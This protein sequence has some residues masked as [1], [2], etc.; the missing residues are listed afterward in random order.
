[1]RFPKQMATISFFMSVRVSVVGGV[2][3]KSLDRPGRKQT[4]ATKLGIYLIYSPRY[5]IHFLARCSNI[6]KA[7]KKIQKFVRPTRSLRQRLPP[8]RTKNGEFSIVFQAKQQVVVRR[9]QIRITGLVIKKLE[10]QVGQFLLGCKCPVTLF[11]QEQDPLGE[12]PAKFFIQNA[13]QL[14]QQR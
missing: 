2:A 3:D 10:A 7:L 12:F 4:T 9:G 5:S 6:C 8:R 1:M 11:V 13:L 14:H